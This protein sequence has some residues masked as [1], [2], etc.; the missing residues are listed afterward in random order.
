[1]AF[2]QRNRLTKSI[3]TK[4]SF[5]LELLRHMTDQAEEQQVEVR[6]LLGNLVN[7]AGSTVTEQNNFFKQVEHEL[8][9]AKRRREKNVR[10]E[11]RQSATRL[12]RAE[13]R[14]EK[15]LLPTLPTFPSSPPLPILPIDVP[16]MSQ[17]TDGM[18]ENYNYNEL[19]HE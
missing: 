7:D 4:Y 9:D 6:Q 19:I 17:L 16:N 14:R 3:S 5:A 15:R 8:M 10:L 1:M 2:L 18:V 13:K 12:R 11:A